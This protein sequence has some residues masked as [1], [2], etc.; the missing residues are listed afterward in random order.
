VQLVLALPDLLALRA[1][2]AAS[3]RAPALAELLAAAG[4][5][6]RDEHGFDAALATR[7]G[8][9]R[10]AD[11]PLAPMRAAA[12]G[13]DPGEA[14]W[15]AADPVTLVAGRDDVQLAG[16]VDDLDRAGADALVA[17]LNAHFTADGL[18]FVAPRPDAFFVRV[19]V[20][21]RLS[22]YP[23][24]LAASRPLSALLPEGGDADAWQ[25]WQSEIQMLLHDHPVNAE[26]ERAGRPPANSIWLS[27]G[28][29]LPPRGA[30]SATICTFADSGIAVALAAHAG[31]PACALPARLDDALAA[32]A[33]A[34]LA[35]VVL[36]PPLD[37]LAL[38]RAWGAP[39]RDALAAGRLET[40]TLLADDGGDAVLWH[41]RRPR[42]PWQR[43][44]RRLGRHDLAALLAAAGERD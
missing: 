15:L 29:T 41:I 12:L 25:R 5:P 30:G 39:A 10:Q 20:P 28:G 8:V 21:P 43:V 31:A 32:A 22:T 26:R 35:V 9:A 7:Y 2:G 44:A 42:W 14:Y 18:T 24:A 38:E 40:V 6:V 36:E 4:A 23:A 3:L 17:T 34:A 19:D 13:V 27:F 33:D 1:A 16:V 11:W 37:A